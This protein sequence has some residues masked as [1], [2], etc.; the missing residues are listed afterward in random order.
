MFFRKLTVI[1]L[2]ILLIVYR[3]GAVILED[4]NKYLS[5]YYSEDYYN[6]GVWFIKKVQEVKFFSVSGVH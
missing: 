2:L 4:P 5:P 1:L 3:V 6:I